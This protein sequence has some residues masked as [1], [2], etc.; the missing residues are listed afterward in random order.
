VLALNTSTVEN[1]LLNAVILMALSAKRHK[2]HADAVWL[3]HR[4]FIYELYINLKKTLQEVI[5]SLIDLEFHV[6]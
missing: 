4:Q 5:E 3:Q 2:R 6:T 1:P